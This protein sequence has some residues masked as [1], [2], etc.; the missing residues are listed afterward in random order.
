M[1]DSQVDALQQKVCG[2][3]PAPVCASGFLDLLHGVTQVYLRWLNFH[4]R[5]SNATVSDLS[6]LTDGTKLALALRDMGVPVWI[7]QTR[8]NRILILTGF[9]GRESHNESA[10]SCPSAREHPN[11]IKCYPAGC[12]FG[13]NQRRWYHR[14]K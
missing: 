2:C 5:T 3:Y 12:S 8:L 7:I 9:L 4:L 14:D 13:R 10:I 6:D 11:R 1:A